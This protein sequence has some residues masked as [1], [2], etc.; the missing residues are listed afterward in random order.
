M[1]KFRGVPGFCISGRK[2]RATVS[3]ECNNILPLHLDACL[4]VHPFTPPP[5]KKG[6]ASLI[7]DTFKVGPYQLQMEL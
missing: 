7:R 6:K 2:K 5:T 4:N 3:V 1:L